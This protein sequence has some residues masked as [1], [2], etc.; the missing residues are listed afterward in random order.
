[1]PEVSTHREYNYGKFLH[2]LL[3]VVDLL[4]LG[5]LFLILCAEHPDIVEHDGTRLKGLALLLSYIPVAYWLS[6]ERKQRTLH[7][8]RIISYALQAVLVHAVFFVGLLALLRASNMPARYYVEFYTMMFVA[9]PLSWTISRLIL[10]Q[11]RSSG[12]NYSRVVIVGTDVTARRLSN[13]LLLDEGY[14]YR[15][16]GFFDT[17]PDADF[18]VGATHYGNLDELEEFV[19][20]NRVNEIFYTLSGE[21]EA[22]LLQVVKIADDAMVE[23]H[24]V[25]KL[26]PYV[27]RQFELTNFS[28]VPVLTPVRNPLSHMFNR[29]VKRAF[30]V[31]FS[32]V[33]LL[34]SPIVFIPIAIAVKC[35]SPGPVFFKQKRTGYRGREFNCWKFRTM[36]VNSD[37]DSVQCT[38]DDPRKTKVGDFL[39]RTSLDELPQFI[40][41]FLGDMSVVGPRPHM[42][43]HTE[44]YKRLIDRYMLRHMVKPGITGWAQVCGFRGNT[45]ELW[46]MEG[47]VRYDVWYVEHWSFM[48]D[49]K[50]ILKTII[51]AWHGEENAY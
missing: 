6:G 5:A 20:K 10:K 45:D 8:D 34:F 13:I 17:V 30:D 41:V 22:E 3:I 19:K 39:R 38:S 48:L 4:L 18:N 23:F 14:G 43:A 27:G 49:L 42:L 40:N 50:I 24:Y 36:R 51:N 28:G 21:R 11:Y 16:L 46:K 26:S 37:A 7:I 9:M 29:W 12:H 31:V 33:A 2:G 47:R 44:Q 35:S 1:M 15:L 32:G 25:P